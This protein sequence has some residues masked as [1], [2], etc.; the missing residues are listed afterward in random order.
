M[1]CGALAGL[2]WSAASLGQAIETYPNPVDHKAYTAPWNTYQPEGGVTKSGEKVELALV[3][4]LVSEDDFGAR[5]TAQET[6]AFIDRAHL[7][8]S[9]IFAS[10]EKAAVLLVQFDCEPGKCRTEIASQGD[11]PDELLQKYYDRLKG[12]APLRV[13]G[14]V[15]FQFTL[16]VHPKSIADPS[17]NAHVN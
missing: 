9:E 16:D 14:E 10:Y 4:L 2:L 15:K 13:T 17:S 3:R 7:A 5:T 8:A 6:A 1:R 12:L 11:P